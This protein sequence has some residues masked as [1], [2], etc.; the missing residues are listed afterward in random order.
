MPISGRAAVDFHLVYDPT[1]AYDGIRDASYD[2]QVGYVIM[3]GR[4]Y[5]PTKAEDRRVEIPPQQTFTIVSKE[6]LNITNGYVGYAFLKTSVARRGILAINT[7]IIDAGWHNH[8]ATTAI[9]FH[10]DAFPIFDAKSFLRITFEIVE[11]DRDDVP[12]P[13]YNKKRAEEYRDEQIA[14]SRRFPASFLDIPGQ[15][16]DIVK[17]AKDTIVAEGWR[18]IGWMVTLVTLIALLLAGAIP[19]I[20]EWSSK[21]FSSKSSE[22]TTRAVLLLQERIRMMEQQLRDQKAAVAGATATP[23]RSTEKV[24]RGNRSG[25]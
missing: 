22:E 11:G 6:V 19:A 24:Q 1:G 13:P 5:D 3:N 20:T 23:S 8:L 15:Q 14:S 21:R 18:R 10:K 4:A 9:N 17:K 25:E 16:D 7:G 2:L 12:I